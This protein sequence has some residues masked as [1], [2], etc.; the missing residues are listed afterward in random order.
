MVPAMQ[1]NL[2]LDCERESRR[3]E[4]FMLQ[5]LCEAHHTRVVLGLS[6]G[7]DS[8]LV[9]SLAVR[10]LGA[11]N[12]LGVLLP[13]CSSNPCS[14]EHGLLIAEKLHIPHS[15][16]E[17]TPMVE[18]LLQ[19]DPAMTAVRKGN[20][21]ARCRMTALYD[22]SASF[23]GLVAGT[24]NRTETLLGYFTMFGDGAA[25][26]KPIAHL[27]KCQVRQLAAYLDIPDVIIN[28]APSADLWEG[29]TDEGD[30]GFTYDQADR[31][32]YLLTECHWSRLQVATAGFDVG[33]AQAVE[34]RWYNTSFKRAETPCLATL[35]AILSA[36]AAAQ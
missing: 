11:G 10:A 2:N 27:Y 19:A 5:T 24:S 4:R 32:L 16:F 6:G 8:A 25:A 21:M 29:Q 1:I 28:K 3:I 9:A 18:P 13:Y 20:I 22:Y 35:N 23:G 15:M 31:V 14:K 12:V 36:P 7:I 33:I 26:L 34:R 17:I 30:L